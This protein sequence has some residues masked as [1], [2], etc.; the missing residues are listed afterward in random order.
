MSKP[1]VLLQLDVDPQ[2]SSFDAFVAIDAGV[3]HLLQYPNV[4]RENVISLV[5]GAIFTRGPADLK[6]TAL[7]FGGSEA[8]AAE[9]LYHI[10]RQS[11]F[12][13]LRVSVM[14]DPNGANTTAAAAV[15]SIEKHL[16]LAGVNLCVLGGTGP[17]GSRVARIAASQGAVVRI[18]SR[19]L[20]RA[21]ST[22]EAILAAYPQARVESFEFLAEADVARAAASFDVLVAAGAAGATFT[23]PDWLDHVP[24]IKVA[25][26]LNAVPPVGLLGI[27][28]R[29]EG[30]IRSGLICYG[31]LGVGGLKMKIHKACLKQLFES[32]E[33]CFN[34][35]EIFEFGRYLVNNA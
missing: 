3:E 20:E 18:C 8:S 12:G 28:P 25:I 29:D 2:A 5:H 9:S 26:D 33:R 31:A 11:F 34:T 22:A 14:C 17:V 4:N 7:F 19:S 27:E 10:A 32:N 21:R 16:P 15:L 35:A 24:G 23:L 13:P 1:K 6:N 30:A